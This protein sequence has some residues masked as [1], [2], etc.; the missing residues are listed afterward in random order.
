MHCRST[1]RLRLLR[2]TLNLSTDEFSAALDLPLRRT[3]RL[4]KPGR[5]PTFGLMAR[6]RRSFPQ[7]NPDWLLSGEGSILLSPPATDGNAIGHNYGTATQTIVHNYH[8]NGL[9]IPPTTRLLL[10]SLLA[11]HLQHLKS[12]A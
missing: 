1:D 12:A 5:K 11:S 3:K 7:V 2:L 9:P 10:I 4:L 8:L 6:V